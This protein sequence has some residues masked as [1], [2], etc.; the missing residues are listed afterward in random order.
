MSYKDLY[1]N[2]K[3]IYIPSKIMNKFIETTVSTEI[4]V[5]G[6]LI[7]TI[8]T[9]IIEVKNLIIGENISDSLY[10]FELDHMTMGK[11]INEMK[12]NED[13]VGIIHSHPAPPFPS[14]ID[15]NGMNLWPVIWVIVDSN[16]GE[17]K[18]WYFDNEINII[19]GI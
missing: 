13:I 2:I 7:G 12:D 19:L 6:L 17:Y 18:A 14:T 1:K 11:A 15:K 10:K 9:E 4:E 3:L 16:T 5:G 8:S